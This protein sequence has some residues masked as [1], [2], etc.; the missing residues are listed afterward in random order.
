MEIVK[1]KKDQVIARKKEKVKQWYLIQEGSVIQKFGFSEVKLG[2]NAII[3]ILERDI[4]VCDYIAGEDTVLAALTCETQDD[5]RR[6]FSGNEKIRS[7]FL[8]AALEQRHQM[9]CLYASLYDRT[10]QFQRY[11]ETIY[12]EYKTLSNKYRIDESN[13]TKMEYFK[14]LEMQHKAESWEVNNSISLVKKF[15]QEYLTLMEKDDSLTVGVIMEASAQMRRVTLGIAEMEYYLS[16]NKDVL[17]A[18]SENDIFDLFFDLTINAYNKKFDI[19]ELNAKVGS[20]VEFA[21]KMNIYNSKLI[22]RRYSE[23]NNY[24]FTIGIPDIDEDTGRVEKVRKE[25]DVVSE[26]CLVHILA[27][28]GYKDDEIES[29]CN[30]IESYRNLPDMLSTDSLAYSLRKQIS[31]IF[32]DVYYRAFMRSIKEE[33][34]PDQ[35]LDMFFNFGFMDVNFTGEENVRE[36]YDLTAHL[37]ICRSENIY[38]IYEWLKCIYRGE[39]EP[40]KNEFDLNYQAYL[41]EER[42]SGNITQEEAIELLNN[43]EKKV[44]FEIRNMFSSVNRTTYGKVTT[45]CPVLGEYDLINSIDK[46]LVTAEK[47]ENAMNEI[48]KLDYSVFYREVLFSDSARGINCEMIMTEILP[49]IILM[50]NAGTKAMMWQETAGVK[51]DTPARFMF[52]IFTAVD[53]DDLMLET[54]GRYHWEMCRKVEGIRWNDVRERSLTAEY[55]TYI[56]FY[57]KNNDLST[58]AKEKVKSQ[59]VRSKNNY[60]EVFVKDYINWMKFES[61]GS[62]RLNKV[63]RDIVVRYCPFNKKVRNDLKSNPIY[64]NSIQRFENE[65]AK[66]LQRYQGL[67]DKY[68]K[69]GGEI[70]PELQENIDFY[71]M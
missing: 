42:K 17:I 61:K 16:Y 38:T 43:P 46:M 52:P 54:I 32:Y 9:L 58:E 63:A 11:V 45:F 71:E 65:T 18:E 55:C 69:A 59:L 22:T 21:E 60:R 29:I 67:Y 51:T 70:T 6:I 64:Q 49:D 62:F 10:Q 44:E 35:I 37:D 4:F 68:V 3:G 23:F 57:R 20:I 14:P 12:D 36:L 5:L 2:R 48:R 19:S 28:A 27:Y 26:D 66:K 13:F 41:T 40:S 47:L 34:S 1:V 8:R 15:L 25:I 53:V 7:I 33:E 50:P 39:K 24:D 56:Q 30:K 31:V